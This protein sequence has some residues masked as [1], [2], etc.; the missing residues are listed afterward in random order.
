MKYNMLTTYGLSTQ[1]NSHN[2]NNQIHGHGQGATCASP[3][4]NFNS[5]TILKIYS[6][7]THGCIIKD[8]TENTSQERDTDM[9]VDNQ[10]VQQNDGKYNNNEK[11][12]MQLV[13]NNINL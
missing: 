3:S 10:T 12:L 13:H 2:P 1:T 4:W 8:P 5:D 9:F 6:K 7:E 11:T